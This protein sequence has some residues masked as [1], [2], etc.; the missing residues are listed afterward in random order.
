MLGFV[1]LWLDLNYFITWKRLAFFLMFFG[2]KLFPIIAKTYAVIEA[3]MTYLCFS[4]TVF[5]EN[6]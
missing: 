2:I 4:F 3:Q 6:R 5:L 1:N